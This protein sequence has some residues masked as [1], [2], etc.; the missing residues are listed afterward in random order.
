MAEK[1]PLRC[2]YRKQ[3]KFLKKV[4]F[5]I[6]STNTKVEVTKLSY[7]YGISIFVQKSDPISIIFVQEI[8]K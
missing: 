8:M 6:F 7:G 4:D 5:Q 2:F 3:M 1:L